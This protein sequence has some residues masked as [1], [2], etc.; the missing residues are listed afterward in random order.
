MLVIELTIHVQLFMFLRKCG[1]F[2][3]INNYYFSL[4]YHMELTKRS[5]ISWNKGAFF[6]VSFKYNTEVSPS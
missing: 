2:N 3:T 4:I 5:V 1:M 6:P